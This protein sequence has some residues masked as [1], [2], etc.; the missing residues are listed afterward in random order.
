MRP[1]RGEAG[2]L[3]SRTRG[4]KVLSCAN[5]CEGDKDRKFAAT[6]TTSKVVRIHQV[7]GMCQALKAKP[8]AKPDLVPALM[9]LDSEMK[10]NK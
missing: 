1:E 8:E 5:G 2:E 3:E 9:S 7:L 4:G 6:T 10:P